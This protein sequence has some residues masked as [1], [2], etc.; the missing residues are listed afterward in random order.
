MNDLRLSKL[1]QLRKPGLDVWICVGLFVAVLAVYGQV[2]SHAFVSFDD[3]IYVTENPQVRGGLSWDGVVWAMTTFHDA[4]WFPVTWLSHMLDCQL[5]GMDSGWHHLT[6]VWIHALSTL[7]LF[8]VLRR[9][10]GA[11]WRS[12]FVA[13]LFG[14]HP[15]HVESV[16]W[17]AER[18]DVL[19]G[20]FWMLTLAAY[21]R[22]VARPAPTRYLL[23]LLAFCLGLM[24]KP[25]LVT[26]PAVLILLDLWP[27]HRGF[28][29]VEKIPFFVAS[30]AVSI[31]ACV[32]HQTGG[33]VATFDVVPLA[34]RI[35]N[36]VIT[37]VVYVRQMF[38]P[39]HLAVFYPYPLQSLV[40]PAI[41]AGITL[42]AVTAVVVY[43]FPRRPYLAVGWFWYVVTLLPVI[44]LIQTGSQARA[45]RYTYIPMIGLSMAVAWGVSEALAPWP[46]IVV[47]LATVA[48]ASCLVLTWFQV[49]YWQDDISLYQHAIDAVPDNYLARFN[50]AS[51]LEARGRTDEAVAQLRAAV[52]VRPLYVP[53]R[54][55][56]GQLLALQGHPD[57][58]LQELET[59]VRQRPDDAVTR[60]RLGSVL[61]S[62]GRPKDAAAEFSEVVR[63]QPDNADAHFNL[64]IALA[65][66]GFLQDAAREF[67]ATV[68]LR[69]GDAPARFNLGIALARLDKLDDAIV[70]FSE[71]VRLEPDFAE[72]RQA[73]EQATRL[74]ES[75]AKR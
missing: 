65:Q 34:T 19:S 72:A 21:A 71:A 51:D 74:R 25:M 37:Y 16:A 53:A 14:V 52:R 6:N 20:L 43:D 15:L 18:K 4:N 75:P 59:A 64:G 60:F 8:A 70:Q 38:W 44:G 28:R 5:F 68:R 12:A 45:D 11:R 42:A 41:F 73:L 63:R 69:P 3:P 57:E 24:A 56:L 2:R 27:L 46:K 10:T 29:I 31:V 49:G 17:I 55:E 35:E 23:A 7:L 58:A 26:L 54:A 61:G 47:A 9:M 22:Y 62:V 50:L 39:T 1:N 30:I 33:A 36:G 48:T 67:S 40:L 13:L 66:L 32:A